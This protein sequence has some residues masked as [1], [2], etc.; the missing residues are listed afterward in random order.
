MGQCG[1]HTTRDNEERRSQLNNWKP[2]HQHQIGHVRKESN[3][4]LEHG[5]CFKHEQHD[6]N[7]HNRLKYR[8]SQKC[9]AS[10]HVLYAPK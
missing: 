6:V 7:C 9:Y 8:N 2:F 1:T 10:N 4:Q 3:Q 5:E